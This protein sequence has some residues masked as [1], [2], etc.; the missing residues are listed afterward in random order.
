MLI[1]YIM[2]RKVKIMRKAFAIGALFCVLLLTSC[3]RPIVHDTQISESKHDSTTDP[4]FSPRN[5][6]EAF[7]GCYLDDSAL[8][9]ERERALPMFSITIGQSNLEDNPIDDA[10]WNLLQEHIGE[11]YSSS[12]EYDSYMDFTALWEKEMQ[13]ALEILKSKLT[14]DLLNALNESQNYWEEYEKVDNELGLSLRL[15]AAHAEGYVRGYAIPSAAKAFLTQRLRALQLIEYCEAI[16]CIEANENAVEII[17]YE[18]LFE[19]E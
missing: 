15:Q 14:G 7:Y 1:F 8:E 12:L 17:K 9:L 19:N 11:P 6:W 2:Y 3:T 5:A 10:Y 18:Y 4:I 16:Y 13:N